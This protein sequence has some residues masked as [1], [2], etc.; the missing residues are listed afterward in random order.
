MPAFIGLDLAWTP[1]HATGICV[2]EGDE[3]GLR[4]VELSCET[5]TPAAFANFCES[6]GD[7]VVVA[8]DAPLVVTD[9]RR[10]EAELARVFGKYR[11]SAYSA[12]L[13]FLTRMNGLAGPNLAMELGKRGLPG[14][15]VRAQP[16][17]PWPRCR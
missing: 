14:R 16:P 17:C 10:A 11:A 1:H 7:D 6:F 12:N 4:F 5:A 8:I 13:G 3:T 2:F 9:D 15:A